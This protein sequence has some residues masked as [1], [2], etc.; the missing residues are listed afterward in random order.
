MDFSK[1]NSGI[2]RNSKVDLPKYDFW[3]WWHRFNFLPSH[4]H[5]SMF[6]WAF[7]WKKSPEREMQSK[8]FWKVEHL[9]T[10]IFA[11][12]TLEPGSSRPNQIKSSTMGSYYCWSCISNLKDKVIILYKK[13]VTALGSGKIWIL[14]PD[15]SR[16]KSKEPKAGDVRSAL[17]TL[18]P[19]TLIFPIISNVET[20]FLKKIKT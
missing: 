9:V 18:F 12:C 4:F 1:Q 2:F 7:S 17:C 10:N 3:F 6:W 16:L 8:V 19:M 20:N 5:S 13:N 15:W 11:T 14:V